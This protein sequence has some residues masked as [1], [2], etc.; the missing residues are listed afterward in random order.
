MPGKRERSASLRRVQLAGYAEELGIELIFF[1]P[2][3]VFDDAILGLVYG[4]GQELSVLYDEAKVLAAMQEHHGWDDETA[5][6][7]FEF[8]TIGGYLGEATP[9]FLVQGPWET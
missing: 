5:R 2:P 4:F 9:R 6:E 7:F 8:N 1:D 3:E